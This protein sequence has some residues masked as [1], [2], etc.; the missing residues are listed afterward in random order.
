[1][2]KTTGFKMLNLIFVPQIFSI[3][4]KKKKKAL[5]HI[6]LLLLEDSSKREQK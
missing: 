2:H 5:P 6:T 4:L 1:M 3:L